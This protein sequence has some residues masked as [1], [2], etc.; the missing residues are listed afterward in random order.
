MEPMIMRGR[1]VA[2]ARGPGQARKPRESASFAPFDSR[3][4][5]L[6]FAAFQGGSVM[7]MMTR[8]EPFRDL[9]RLQDEMTRMFDDRLY[10]AGESVGWTPAC[11]IY[12]DEEGV[13]LRFELAGVDPK[14]VDVRFENGVLTVKGE[15][16]LEEEEKR[17]NYHR[18]E[19]SFGTFTRSFSLPGSVDAEKIKAETKNGVLTVT[20]PE[21]SARAATSVSS[22]P[23]AAPALC[24]RQS[25]RRSRGLSKN[26]NARASQRARAS[27]CRPLRLH[28]LNGRGRD[29][30]HGRLLDPLHL[31]LP[32]DDHALLDHERG[33]LDVPAHP[34]RVVEL[35]GALRLHVAVDLA[36][37]DDAATADLGV[38]LGALADDENVVRHDR[39]GEL[40][41]DADG[42]FERQL[43]FELR[44][45]AE[46][47]IEIAGARGDGG[48]FIALQH[49]H[50]LR[51]LAGWFRGGGRSGRDR[52]GPRRRRLLPELVPDRHL[53][54]FFGSS[55]RRGSHP[56]SGSEP[57]YAP[58]LASIP[59]SSS[60]DVYSTSRRPAT[61]DLGTTRHLAPRRRCRRWPRS[62]RDVL[63]PAWA[64]FGLPFF[65]SWRTSASVARTESDSR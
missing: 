25:P 10:R 29:R 65:V 34:R 18:V 46:Q 14:D 59:S 9:A 43:A 53:L 4:A 30:L 19:R 42:P 44:A 52:A 64:V 11:D 45:A 27:S 16:K 50:G 62:R 61:A 48:E 35:D 56:T 38:H 39:A 55:P 37:D 23:R 3:S 1:H 17:E 60:R 47:R 58:I 41:V 15:R 49:G 20:L 54:F 2:R 6:T 5:R 36:V 21:T 24:G 7:A 63:S 28:G 33:G 32:L 51:L 12:E 26:R 31:A 8:W 22:G 40:A 57:Y 13:A